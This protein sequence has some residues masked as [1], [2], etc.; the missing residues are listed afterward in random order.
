[1]R[2]AHSELIKQWAD[3]D[4]L[5]VEYLSDSGRWTYCD[6]P[7]WDVNTKY[8]LASPTLTSLTGSQLMAIFALAKASSETSLEDALIK[9]ANEVIKQYIEDNE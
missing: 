4:T 5:V 1:M 9:L 8:R 6:L 2:R 3:D 7:G